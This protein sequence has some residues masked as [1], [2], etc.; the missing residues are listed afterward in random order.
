MEWPS[1]FDYDHRESKL[2]LVPHLSLKLA[3]TECSF[4]P[5]SMEVVNQYR[6]ATLSPRPTWG[7]FYPC[8]ATF[9]TVWAVPWALRHLLQTQT[10]QMEHFVK[11]ITENTVH[12]LRFG[13]LLT[14]LQG[15]RSARATLNMKICYVHRS[16]PFSPSDQPF[17]ANGFTTPSQ[18]IR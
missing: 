4:D 16:L 13:L 17:S 6:R 14:S 18:F 10:S 2:H 1:I 7:H 3:L 15:L 11:A 8:Q 9:S 5:L 12:T